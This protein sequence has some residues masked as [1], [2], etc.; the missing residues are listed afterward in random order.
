MP[1]PDIQSYLVAAYHH[2]RDTGARPTARM[3][4]RKMAE[5][6]EDYL[7]LA[8]AVRSKFGDGIPIEEWQAEVRLPL[9]ALQ[10]IPAAMNDYE[11]FV[12]ALP[13]MLKVYRKRKP[14]PEFSSDDLLREG[15]SPPDVR[16]VGRVMEGEF[17]LSTSAGRTSWDSWRYTLSPML[18]KFAD[19]RTASEYVQRRLQEA[20]A[21]ELRAAKGFRRLIP[22]PSD[23]MRQLL[24]KVALWIVGGVGLPLLVGY[25]IFLFG[26][27]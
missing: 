21:D 24:K 9:A 1:R 7:S 16:V 14:E 22:A 13:I 4:E 5:M 17:L 3:M 15:W 11:V 23:S 18:L 26:W 8:Q 25:L 12:R 6:G 2:Y 20:G 19:A 27:T 10:R